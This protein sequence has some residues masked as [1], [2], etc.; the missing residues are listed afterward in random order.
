MSSCKLAA[1][2]VW[3]VDRGLASSSSTQC[4]LSPSAASGC[5]GLRREEV[6]WGWQG[7]RT[8]ASWLCLF[9]LL[10]VHARALKPSPKAGLA[11]L[12]A[13]EEPVE[14]EEPAGAPGHCTVAVVLQGLQLLR[15]GSPEHLPCTIA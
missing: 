8:L 6:L 7:R 13:L 1:A 15:T 5:G 2:W 9:R 11:W 14:L 10:E 4:L 12:K 3:P